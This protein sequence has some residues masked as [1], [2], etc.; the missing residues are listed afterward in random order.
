[1]ETH[2]RIAA[3]LRIVWSGFGL[4]VGILVLTVFS[5]VGAI[6]GVS[7]DAEAQQALPL[8][9][10]IGTFV[11][12]FFALLSLPGLLTGWGLL[13]YQPWARIVN[14]VLSAFDLFHFPIGTALGAYSIWVMLQPETVA[15]FESG[16]PLRRYPT[17]L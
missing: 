8:V 9:M 5:G 16:P 17:H 15:L 3:W 12:L 14:I 6:L 11:A 13:T 7:G 1:M 2:V 4:L 10:V